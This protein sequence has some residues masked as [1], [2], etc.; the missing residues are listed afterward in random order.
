MIAAHVHLHLQ[1]KLAEVEHAQASPPAIAYCF[2]KTD[3]FKYSLA[4]S[5]SALI[6]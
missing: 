3:H 2:I 4:S 1:C 6:N 5:H